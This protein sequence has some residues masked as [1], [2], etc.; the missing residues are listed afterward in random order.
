MP[1]LHKLCTYTHA[2]TRQNERHEH[3]VLHQT[4]VSQITYDCNMYCIST[5]PHSPTCHIGATLEYCLIILLV[6]LVCVSTLP[7]FPQQSNVILAH[8]PSIRDSC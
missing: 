8:F 4:P 2:A 6:A 7:R 1:I 5:L 3:K